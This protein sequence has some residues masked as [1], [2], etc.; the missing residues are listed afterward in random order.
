MAWL[1]QLKDALNIPSDM[2]LAD[3][4]GI[5]SPSV[6]SGWRRGRTQPGQQ[7]LRKLAALAG[8]PAIEVYR[9]AG[10]IAD[11]DDVTAPATPPEPLPRSLVDLIDLY[12][13]SD[14]DARVV[15]LGQ[16]NFLINAMR[17]R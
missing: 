15:I 1:D 4:A 14:P 9:L 13:E 2:Q 8:R 16:V 10:H 11:D 7:N 12:R 17:R 3:R 5:A 6:I